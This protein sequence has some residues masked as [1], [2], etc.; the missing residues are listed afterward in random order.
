M[1]VL[2]DRTTPTLVH[3]LPAGVRWVAQFVPFLSRQRDLAPIS[4]ISGVKFVSDPVFPFIPLCISRPV[5]A[6]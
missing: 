3:R 6:T 1:R 4:L 5:R 2:S